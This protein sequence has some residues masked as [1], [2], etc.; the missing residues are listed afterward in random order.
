MPMMFDAIPATLPHIKSGRLRGLGIATLQRSAFLPELPTIAE[1]GLPGFDTTSWFCIVG[2]AGL[3][4]AI[5]QSQ[6][7]ILLE[8]GHDQ[9]PLGFGQTVLEECCRLLAPLL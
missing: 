2:P 3:P 4:K 1:S 5:V 9:R 6:G 8:Q 7:G